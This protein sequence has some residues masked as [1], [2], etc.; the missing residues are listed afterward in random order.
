MWRPARA[1]PTAET[2]RLRVIDKLKRVAGEKASS[3]AVVSAVACALQIPR[4]SENLARPAIGTGNVRIRDK[5]D[6]MAVHRSR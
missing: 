6:L 5:D 4:H 1:V 3:R 2:L